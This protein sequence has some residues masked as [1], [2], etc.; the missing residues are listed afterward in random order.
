MKSNSRDSKKM[1]MKAEARVPPGPA[2]APRIEPSSNLEHEL[3]VHQVELEVQNEE[4]RRAQV[5]LE[6]ARDLYSEVFQFAPV[7]YLILSDAGLIK[8]ANLA[9]ATLFGVERSKLLGR[10]FT[11][12]LGRE[13]ADRWYLLFPTL[14]RQGEWLSFRLALQRNDGSTLHTRF[15]C[16]G[17]RT[18]DGKSVVR[19]VV[20]DISEQVRAERALQ[21]SKDRL[22]EVLDEF[23]DGYWDWFVEGKKI[24]LSRR[25]R[26]MLGLT[27]EG[28]ETPQSYDPAWK[29]RIH[30]ED[31]LLAKTTMANLV[32]G[33][34]DAIEVECRWKVS[35]AK[36]KWLRARGRIA[37]RDGSGRAVRIKGTVAD[38]TEFKRLQ[39]SILRLDTR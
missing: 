28:H 18:R 20:S 2:A 13:E 19:A 1:R 34:R 8:D 30:P 29:A 6:E 35:D 39:E 7:G 11:A 9:G 37:K 38:I 16:E 23:Q 33:R 27:D 32:E 3:L 31:R 36:W 4:L 26:T 14:I 25:L 21:D 5:A 24:V 15:A 12:Y 22:S 17:Q 10:P